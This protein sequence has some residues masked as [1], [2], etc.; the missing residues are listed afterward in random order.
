[1]VLCAYHMHCANIPNV[2]KAH[3]VLCILYGLYI[4]HASHCKFVILNDI[5]DCGKR[6][7]RYSR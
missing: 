2:H 6:T 3:F 4:A 7:L 5:F 1:M